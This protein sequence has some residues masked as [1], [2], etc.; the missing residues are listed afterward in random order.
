MTEATPTFIMK[1]TAK[2]GMRD[3]LAEQAVAGFKLAH[4]IDSWLV[5]N[6]AEDPDSIWVVE[7][8]TSAEAVEQHR[9]HQDK[10]H[11]DAIGGLM[12]GP[13]SFTRTTVFP[14]AASYDLP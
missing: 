14:V 6:D 7:T 8:F 13:T 2:P 5:S 10:D 12:A 4:G 9:A 11:V 1:F 3:A